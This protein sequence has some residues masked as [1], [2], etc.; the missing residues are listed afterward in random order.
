MA[1]SLAKP[2]QGWRFSLGRL[3]RQAASLPLKLLRRIFAW[4]FDI[5]EDI[6]EAWSFGAH[7][8][9]ADRSFF[10]RPRQRFLYNGLHRSAWRWNYPQRDLSMRAVKMSARYQ[11]RS[12][13][14]K[15]LVAPAPGNRDFHWWQFS[16]LI[17]SALAAWSSGNAI[18]YRH[19][20]SSD[21]LPAKIHEFRQAAHEM[22]S[23]PLAAY[24]WA[25]LQNE[26]GYPI[27]IRVPPHPSSA[28]Q[29]PKAYAHAPINLHAIE[30]SYRHA[31][32]TGFLSAVNY[33]CG[34]KPVP[35]ESILAIADMESKM[36]RYTVNPNSSA[37]GPMQIIDGEFLRMTGH[38]GAN[39]L[40]LI[41]A[42]LARLPPSSPEAI[43]LRHDTDVLE[44]AVAAFKETPQLPPAL[45][46]EVLAL[47]NGHPVIQLL[48]VAD[49]QI[50]ESAAL[51][52]D[53]G[54]TQSEA[55]KYSYLSY[56]AGPGVAKLALQAYF[57]PARRTKPIAPLLISFYT[58][59]YMHEH[60]THDDAHEKAAQI[61]TE[62]L[63]NNGEQ[64]TASTQ[65]FVE[66]R[67]IPFAQL[68]GGYR[69][70]MDR[71]LVQLAQAQAAL[72][73]QRPPAE[74][75]FDLDAEAAIARV[76]S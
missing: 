58:R 43:Q 46:R 64:L 16:L 44:R 6:A 15:A 30:A 71:E 33:V 14:V 74:H 8:I 23:H 60:M 5:E 37:R 12:T 61:A 53:C 21:S 11:M 51:A 34:L 63:I 2:R 65:E 55:L 66:R 59:Y 39:D 29:A 9:V 45:Q 17:A 18:M 26:K 56:S 31:N 28:Y 7:S 67:T 19:G 70:V 54:L 76:G 75:L 38:Y 68:A 1:K 20:Q 48:F 57:D 4:F 50:E 13:S 41:S 49:A 73:K 47:R 27:W 42:Y 40:P 36:G 10:S 32:D 24:D 35:C 3:F 62:I 22:F 69:L 52:A 72:R 25:P